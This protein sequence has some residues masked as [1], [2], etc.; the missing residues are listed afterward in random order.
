MI[1]LIAV[2][3]VLASGIIGTGV[4][5]WLCVT[6]RI[7]QDDIMNYCFG[8]CISF[9]LLMMCVALVGMAE[10]QYYYNLIH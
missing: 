8:I 6:K 5:M 9:C 4:L 2:F 3:V 10:K 1:T 7:P